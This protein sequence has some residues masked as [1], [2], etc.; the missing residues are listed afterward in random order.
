MIPFQAN[1]KKWAILHSFLLVHSFILF[2]LK[3]SGRL[4]QGIKIE[5]RSGLERLLG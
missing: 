4:L 1:F 2:H 5:K 3:L